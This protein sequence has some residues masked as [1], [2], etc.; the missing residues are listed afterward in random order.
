[1]EENNLSRFNTTYIFK[2][3]RT[4]RAVAHAL[5]TFRLRQLPLV[6]GFIFSFFVFEWKNK[7]RLVFQFFVFSFQVENE[8]RLV[9]LFLGPYNSILSFPSPARV[10]ILGPRL[11][12]ENPKIFHYFEISLSRPYTI[13]VGAFLILPV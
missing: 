9:F 7:K 5:T 11:K 3:M 10:M 13:A 1:M 8:K 6:F 4:G 12:G 2:C